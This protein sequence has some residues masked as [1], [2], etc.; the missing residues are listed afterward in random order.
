MSTVL[1]ARRVQVILNELGAGYS[2][3]ISSIL[4]NRLM[5]TMRSTYHEVEESEP[6]FTTIHFIS[7][8]SRQTFPLGGEL[9][10]DWP[11]AGGSHVEF[12]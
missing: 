11:K 10:S 7:H 4:A 1:R 6:K 5:I 8:N 3:V 12:R 2:F 9:V